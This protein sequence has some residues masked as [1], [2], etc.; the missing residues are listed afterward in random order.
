MTASVM[1]NGIET[2]RKLEPALHIINAVF[3]GFVAFLSA[4]KM[5]SGI[6]AQKVGF[7]A[8]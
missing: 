2:I 1:T 8:I 7:S 3:R 6:A 4:L 5:K